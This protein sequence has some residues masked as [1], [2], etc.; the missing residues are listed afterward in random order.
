[1]TGKSYGPTEMIIRGLPAGSHP[2]DLPGVP[3]GEATPSRQAT[4]GLGPRPVGPKADLKKLS[5]L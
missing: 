2:G 3:A 1:M 5:V 4:I